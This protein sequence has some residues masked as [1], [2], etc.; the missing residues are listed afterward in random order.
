MFVN[1]GA[2]NYEIDKFANSE[3]LKKISDLLTYEAV[4]TRATLAEL[5]NILQNESFVAKTS[6]SIRPSSSKRGE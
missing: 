5:D 1:I 2:N 4:Q 3:Q 6:T